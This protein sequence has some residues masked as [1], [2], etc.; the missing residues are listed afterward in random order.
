[1]ASLALQFMLTHSF[2]GI[3]LLN[4]VYFAPR[5]HI[6]RMSC[7][8]HL[9]LPQGRPDA[10]ALLPAN[11]NSEPPKGQEML[12]RG[13]SQDEDDITRWVSHGSLMPSTVNRLRDPVFACP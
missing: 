13:N 7:Y 3:Y 9:V 12:L 1:M 2:P 5:P 10:P 11:Q 4:I 6:I 8:C